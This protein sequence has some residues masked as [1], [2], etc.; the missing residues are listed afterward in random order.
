MNLSGAIVTSLLVVIIL[1]IGY[2][3][4]Y[5]QARREVTKAVKE[6]ELKQAKELK[7]IQK[8]DWNFDNIRRARI[9]ILNNAHE[10]K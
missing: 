7:F 6:R 2:C 8:R 10:W 3:L 5:W 1:L 4:G 9:T